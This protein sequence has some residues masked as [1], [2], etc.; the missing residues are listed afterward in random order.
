MGCCKEPFGMNRRSNKSLNES[1]RQDTY[2]F[3]QDS[4]ITLRSLEESA[5]FCEVPGSSGK[6]DEVQ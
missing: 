3:L 6:F 2:R 1:V 4:G 5:K